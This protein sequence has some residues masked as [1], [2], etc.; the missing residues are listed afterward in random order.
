MVEWW[1]LQIV[2]AIL[3]LEFVEPLNV[4]NKVP[5]SLSFMFLLLAFIMVGTQIS[6]TQYTLIFVSKKLFFKGVSRQSLIMWL[7]SV[8]LYLIFPL[9]KMPL[10]V[11]GLSSLFL[12]DYVFFAFFRRWRRRWS[13][14]IIMVLSQALSLLVFTWLV[15]FKVN[16]TL[17]RI[18][19][20]TIDSFI[21]MVHFLK[22][23]ILEVYGH[24]V[25]GKRWWVLTYFGLS[26]I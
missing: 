11:K 10:Q 24:R 2:S 18:K 21:K 8:P 12:R 25:S 13:I 20:N 15:R 1:L 22:E 26:F 6:T 17:A 19:E 16:V 4:L 7:S 3:P 9:L 5:W 23:G 14:K